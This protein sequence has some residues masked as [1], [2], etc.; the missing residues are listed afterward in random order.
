MLIDTENPSTYPNSI[1]KAIYQYIA[2]ELFPVEA[3]IRERVIVNDI[4]ISCAVED[5]FSSYK[6]EPLYEQLSEIMANHEIILYHATKVLDPQQIREQGLKRTE[7]SSYSVSLRKALASLGAGNADMMIDCVHKE[8]E[9][10]Y[11]AKDYKPQLCFFSGLKL[12]HCEG[13][14]G[15]DQFCQNIGGELARWSLEKEMPE[16]Y[17][18]L[19][20]NG[21]PLIVKFRLPFLDIANYQQETVLRQFILYYMAKFFWKWDYAI[22]FDGITHTDIAPYQ[23]LE[24]IEYDK[25]VDYE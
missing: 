21:T 20:D 1:Q 9:R 10:K 15:Y 24:L 19:K 17:Q 2:E 25:E 23:I 8:Y 3:Q 18:L 7:W 13:S 14:P 5:Y 4:D 16:A 6:A 11:Q 22:R 12:A